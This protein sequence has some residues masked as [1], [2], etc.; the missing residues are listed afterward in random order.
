MGRTL[1]LAIGAI[2]AVVFSQAPEYAQQYQQRI[3]GA[4]DELAK[5]IRTFDADAGE[6]GLGREQALVRLKGN[7]DP[8]A[9][10][11]GA[12][13]DEAI[14]RYEQLIRQ[15]A[16]L[17]GAGPVERVYVLA[18]DFDPEI[19]SAA[20]EDFKP[21]VPVT[22]GGFV[23]A[24][25]GFLIALLGGGTARAATRAVRRKRRRGRLEPSRGGDAPGR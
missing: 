19:G 10:R 5:I 2:F 20:A 13:M 6:E 1:T 14:R 4:I 17:R 16:A 18:R 21:A 25:I 8:L 3:G 15:R 24:A 9:A 12:R 22:I 7:I 11:R 23:A